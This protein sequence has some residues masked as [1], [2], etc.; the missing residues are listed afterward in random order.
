MKVRVDA[1]EAGVD[2]GCLPL[3]EGGQD[4]GALFFLQ[5]EKA[6]G[7]MLRDELQGLEYSDPGFFVRKFWELVLDLSKGLGIGFGLTVELVMV[8]VLAGS[9]LPN[10]AGQVLELL[11]IWGVEVALGVDAGE[12]CT[13]PT[14]LLV[15]PKMAEGGL[16]VNLCLVVYGWY[17]YERDKVGTKVLVKGLKGPRAVG[18]HGKVLD[19]GGVG[20]LGLLGRVEPRSRMDHV[21]TAVGCL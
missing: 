3:D 21:V 20:I 7:G 17:P 19:W 8:T 16:M 10:T 15:V 11:C 14:V 12:G 13:A 18:N 6:G 2:A 5:M 1:L 9:V 4:L